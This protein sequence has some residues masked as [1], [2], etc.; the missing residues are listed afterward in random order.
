[1]TRTNVKKLRLMEMARR[2][3][4]KAVKAARQQPD[5]WHQACNPRHEH[6][7]KFIRHCP[8]G[9]DTIEIWQPHGLDGDWRI[10]WGSSPIVRHHNDLG[11]FETAL[12]AKC[13]ADKML[14]DKMNGVLLD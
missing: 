6:L 4:E 14:A 3:E 12:E 9:A 1:M 10:Y 7:P 5:Q 13:A 2:A 8:I 11:S